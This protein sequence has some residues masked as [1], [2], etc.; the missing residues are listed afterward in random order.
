[1]RIGVFTDHP[2]GQYCQVDLTVRNVG[3]STRNLFV[4]PERLVDT[5]GAEHDVNRLLSGTAF[6]RRIWENISEADTASGTLVFDIPL[7]ATADHLEL[8]DGP[9]S[10][11]TT[12]ALR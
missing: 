12:I 5:T 10:G 4:A 6:S 9:A 2:D 8:H 7:T 11:G 1:L 3:G